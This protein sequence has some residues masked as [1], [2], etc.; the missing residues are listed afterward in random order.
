MNWSQDT[1]R[2]ILYLGQ[3]MRKDLDSNKN[4]AHNIA[5]ANDFIQM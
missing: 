2:Q 3:Y 5:I 1:L 4:C